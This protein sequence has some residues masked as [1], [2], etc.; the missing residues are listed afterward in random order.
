[1]ELEDIYAGKHVLDAACEKGLGIDLP[2][3]AG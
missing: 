1:M 2:I 3:G